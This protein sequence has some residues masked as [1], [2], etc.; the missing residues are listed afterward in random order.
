MI[1]VM[2]MYDLCDPASVVSVLLCFSHLDVKFT[3]TLLRVAFALKC[4]LDFQY[5]FSLGLGSAY[6]PLSAFSMCV[7]LKWTAKAV[8]YW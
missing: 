5:G 1:C 3:S 2:H 7:Y 4:C 8:R 6:P